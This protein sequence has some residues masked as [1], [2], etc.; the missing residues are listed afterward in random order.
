MTNEEFVRACKALG[1]ENRVKILD[2]IGASRSH[3]V[4]EPG[5]ADDRG[6]TVL[7]CVDEIVAKFDMAQSTISQHLKELHQAG[8]LERHKKAQWVYYTVNCKMI[9]EMTA[10]LRNLEGKL[11]ASCCG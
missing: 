6:Q 7:C 5:G 8:L 10:Y 2:A 4:C 1:N 11:K 9:E 3:C